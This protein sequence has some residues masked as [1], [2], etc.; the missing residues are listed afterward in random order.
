MARSETFGCREARPPQWRLYDRESR[1]ARGQMEA[2][3]LEGRDS[4]EAWRA[5]ALRGEMKGEM[6]GGLEELGC[7]D[8][9]QIPAA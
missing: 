6:G 2:E 7:S 4:P 9:S 8:G 5:C 3:E 1:A